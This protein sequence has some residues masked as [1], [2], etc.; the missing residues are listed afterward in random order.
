MHESALAAEVIASLASEPGRVQAIDDLAASCGEPIAAV[1]SACALLM[2]V[3][4]LDSTTSGGVCLP[5]E[6]QRSER[7]V[8]VLVENTA[9]VAHLVTAL[10]ES[11][12]YHVL[13]AD[14]L[15][16]GVQVALAICPDLVIADSFAATARDALDRLGGLRE[17]A[18]PAPTLVFTAH[19]DVDETRVQAAGYAGLLPKPFDIDDLLARVSREIGERRRPPQSGAG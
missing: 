5:V 19:R 3:G 14:T 2:R 7:P 13:I 8:V 9:A 12:G 11:E 16:V 4:L 10:L 18:D 6:K 15:A 17:A 1:A